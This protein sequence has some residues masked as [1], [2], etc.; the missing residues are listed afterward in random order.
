MSKNNKFNK[1]R[2]ALRSKPK[3]VLKKNSSGP[4]KINE[5]SNHKILG[6]LDI[7]RA[8][9]GRILF[10]SK[11]EQKNVKHRLS[12]TFAEA[13]SSKTGRFSARKNCIPTPI[14]TRPP[15]KNHK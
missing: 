5:E 14:K 13:R 7:E 1:S 10:D 9:D 3:C 12:F 4:W 15:K 6:N 11:V 2:Q 8:R